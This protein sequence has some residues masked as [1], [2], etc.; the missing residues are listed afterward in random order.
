MRAEGV[1]R[2]PFIRVPFV[3]GLL[4][5]A[6]VALLATALPA[7]ASAAK[8]APRGHTLSA[9][10]H[11]LQGA[12][13]THG[14]PAVQRRAIGR[15][16]HKGASIFVLIHRGRLCAA[17]AKL[18]GL[19]R[20]AASRRLK[21]SKA[22][23]AKLMAAILSVDTG[24]LSSGRARRCGGPKIKPGATPKARLLR[25]TKHGVVLKLSLPAAALIPVVKGGKPFVALDM[26]GLGGI[27]KA[28]EPAV[29]AVQDLLAIPDGAKVS[30]KVT[31]SS[32]YTVDGVDLVPNQHESVDGIVTPP[33]KQFGDK[34]FTIDRKTYN[35]NAAFPRKS[36]GGKAL[37]P[38]RDLN[39]GDLSL[40]GAQYRPRSKR[41]TVFT[42]LTVKVSFKGGTGTFG[43]QRLTSPWNEPAQHLYKSIFSN[44]SIALANL[45]SIAHTLFC[46][47]EILIV[48]SPGLRAAAD[49]LA[50]A[51]QHDGFRTKVVEVGSGAG[52]IGTTADQIRT[53]VQNEVWSTTCTVR[54]SYLILLGDTS[55]VPTF[56]DDDTTPG[57]IPSDLDYAL[58]IHGLY[59]P[60]LAVGRISAGDLTTANTI[61]GKIIGYEDSPPFDA[62]FYK[63]ATVTAYFQ[64]TSNSDTQDERGFTRTAE[65]VRNGLIANGKTVS[66]VYT[67]AATNPL[68]Y[69]TGDPLPDELKKPGF[70][71]NGTGT[72]VINQIN[73][74]RFLV[75]HRDHG[76]ETGVTNPDL[77]TGD[78]PSMTN[79]GKLP[80]VFLIDCSAGTFDNPGTPS[81]GEAMQ[82][83][84]GGGAVA[85]IAASRV[86]PSETNNVFTLGLVD[87]IWPSILPYEGSSTPTYRMGDV[88]NLGKL[89]VLL[90]G[91]DLGS[92][93]ARQENRLYQLFGD[94]SM[95]IR[96]HNPAFVTSAAASLIGQSV[97]IAIGGAA[98][99]RAL[100]TLLQ[101]GVPIGK[102]L[103][104]GDGG[105]TLLPDAAILP[106]TRL[107]LVI[108]QAG[109][110]KKTI[111][112]RAGLPD[113]QY[114][115][116]TQPANTRTWRL[117]VHNAGVVAAGPFSA[118]VSALDV[119]GGSHTRTFSFSHGIAAGATVAAD[120]TTD[121]IVSAACPI[122]VSIDPA[123]AVAE[124]DETNNTAQLGESSGLCVT[125]KP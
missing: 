26:P 70:A 107:D 14:L 115:A 108:D 103:L 93:S 94:P 37:G 101:N 40:F 113:L 95:E 88:L 52:Q 43:D 114:G 28:G 39:V 83:R 98:G 96:L 45:G 47:E 2:R 19:R 86:S 82:R 79:G 121:M 123:N 64:T 122:T 109:Y 33:A 35:S 84:A 17:R 46:G 105:A 91:A 34:P 9:A 112:L 1:V 11:T 119:N 24:I 58:K 7:G 111:P 4:A 68:T 65:A 80:V 60:D 53:Y 102:A 110:E 29:P 71:W 49:T 125:T 118:T 48:T 12:L 8:R 81:L 59:L 89:H 27:G 55:N 30:V 90:H 106:G 72:D 18:A 63:N 10:V 62:A 100:A 69:D 23:R 36:A 117:T 92:D 85:V 21:L 67:T 51:R 66:R 20:A 16:R 6:L 87:A 116:L 50:A 61:V 99:K 42:S 54:P 22:R 25:S 41:L 56:P 31:G 78:V 13:S 76:Y 3:R 104:G 38:L 5:V 73:T 120:S 97:H 15:L 124:S 77:S 32:S 44:Y 74:G 75:V 57:S